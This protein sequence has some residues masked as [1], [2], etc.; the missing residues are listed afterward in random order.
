[1]AGIANAQAPMVESYAGAS[2]ALF[3]D[4]IEPEA[5]GYNLDPSPAPQG[6]AIL[7]ARTQRADCVLRVRVVTVT[8]KR[9]DVGA[10]WGLG[11]VTLERL[12]GERCPAHDFTLDV[13]DGAAGSSIL[14]TFEG[15]LVGVNLVAFV[16]Q[17]R[18]AGGEA[19][20]HFHMAPEGKEELNAVRVA[21]LLGEV[22]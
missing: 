8:S 14:R 22:R 5:V 3:D 17:F 7:R 15:R 20:F 21:A 11:L 13:A 4:G 16:R 12:A 2:T 10:H 6:D 18:G 1:M 19:T 9:E